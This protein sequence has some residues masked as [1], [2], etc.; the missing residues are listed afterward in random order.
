M[1][2]P[3]DPEPKRAQRLSVHGHAVIAEVPFN[4]RAQPLAH[5]RDGIVHAPPE[6]FFHLI[7]LRLQPFTNRLPQHREISV[8]S[9]LSADMRKA[10]EIERLRFPLSAPLPV[11]SRVSA[12]LQKPRFVGMQLKLELPKPLGEIRPEPFGIRFALESSH[13]IVRVPHRDDLALR[14]LSTPCLNPQIE[15][16][17]EIDIGHQR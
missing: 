8:V 1:P 17:M 5:F 15:D 9:L 10:E 3:A 12:E 14:S 11:M 16:V 4:D 13:D 7:Q 2:E 6:F